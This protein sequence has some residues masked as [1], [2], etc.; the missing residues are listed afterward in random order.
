MPIPRLPK[1]SIRLA[2]SASFFTMREDAISLG[3]FFEAIFSPRN[4]I[5][6]IQR[7]MKQIFGLTLFRES[8][9]RT[10]EERYEIDGNVRGEPNEVLLSPVITTFVIRRPVFYGDDL[11]KVLGFEDELRRAGTNNAGLLSQE[12]RKPFIFIK[13]EKAPDN[14]GLGTI[15]TF[16]RGCK[17]QMI[18]RL[19]DVSSGE[20]GVFEDATIMYAGRQQFTQ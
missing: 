13:S 6:E 8:Q 19:Y 5:T 14:S 20:L 2:T 18:D 12:F 3:S 1:T 17:I 7:E 11:I 10:T 9:T 4:E 16:Y 15:V